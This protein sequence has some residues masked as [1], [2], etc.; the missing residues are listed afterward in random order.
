MKKNRF[1]DEARAIIDAAESEGRG[2][3]P[4]ERK[5]VHELLTRAERTD[6]HRIADELMRVEMP[7]EG[8]ATAYGG[9]KS[10]GEAFV[11]SEGFK[12]I[13]DAG[14]RGQTYSTGAVEVGSFSRK[15]GTI[16]ESGQ[17]AGF[18]PVPQVIPGVVA[19]LFEQAGVSDLIPST[20]V[21]SSSVRYV[22]EGTAT[23]GAAGVA[24]GGEKP[25]SDLAYSTVDEPVKKIA[26]VI[27]TSDELLEDATGVRSFVDSRLTLFVKLEEER[28]ILRGA[29]TDELVGIFGRGI[30]SHARGTVDNNAVALAKVIANTRGSSHLEPDALIMH[31]SNWLSTRLLTDTAGQFF[32][33]GPFSG[34]YGNAG[35]ASV[36][37]QTLWGKPVILSSVV[38]LGTA[39]VGSFGQAAMLYR[40]GGVT[41]EATNSHLDFFTHNQVAIRAESRQA[42]GVFRPESFTEVTGLN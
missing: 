22:H 4:A 37:G 31:P 7:R 8:F 21:T 29:G 6:D 17:G 27:T 34:A 35:D 36:F 2:L 12:R 1:A 32:G 40:R 18:V 23:S 42:L 28:Q 10:W 41:V 19:T 11:A 38:G 39:L 14:L 20:P 15:A 3:R 26:T 24:E 33:G 13:A 5:H 16:Y 25:A 9:G 30:N